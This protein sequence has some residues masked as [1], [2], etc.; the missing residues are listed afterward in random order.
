MS[1]S[2]PTH[3]ESHLAWAQLGQ[4]CLPPITPRAM[5]PLPLNPGCLMNG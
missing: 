4:L 3:P 2:P 5:Q 1:G